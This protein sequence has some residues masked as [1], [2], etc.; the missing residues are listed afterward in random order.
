M[1]T[2]VGLIACIIIVCIMYSGM[3]IH[4]LT[5]KVKN[6]VN[7]QVSRLKQP[8]P[9]EVKKMGTIIE[10]T[11]DVVMNLLCGVPVD[12]SGPNNRIVQE[13][14]SYNDRSGSSSWS[15]RNMDKESIEDLYAAYLCIVEDN[16]K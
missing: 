3:L 6:K 2:S 11:R 13:Y 7:K 14:Y 1:E 12:Y 4:K 5:T 8:I 9:K 15:R 16:K 10:L